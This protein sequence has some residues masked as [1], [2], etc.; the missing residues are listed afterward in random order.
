MFDPDFKVTSTFEST[1]EAHE[2]CPSSKVHW[3]AHEGQC[4]VHDEWFLIEDHEE[5]HNN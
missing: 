4:D 2:D 5:W 3:N 1:H